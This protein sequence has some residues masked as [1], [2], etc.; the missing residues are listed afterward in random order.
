MNYI[1]TLYWHTNA[2]Y[3]VNADSREEAV[4]KAREAAEYETSEILN[5]LSEDADPEVTQQTN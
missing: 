3:S 4:E 5:N 1:V 2:T